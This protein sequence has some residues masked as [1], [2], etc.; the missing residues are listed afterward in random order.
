MLEGLD[1]A[2]LIENG[3]SSPETI[4]APEAGAPTLDAALREAARAERAAERADATMLDLW[5]HRPGGANLSALERPALGAQTSWHALAALSGDG[6]GVLDLGGGKDVPLFAALNDDEE[7]VVVG[8]RPNEVDEDDEG[9]SWGY[10]GGF[11]PGG[12]DGTRRGRGR[13]S[14]SAW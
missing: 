14:P 1:T 6:G 8:P 4:A 11:Y 2:P 10:G 7:I 9:G 5:L 12:P 13:A 3:A